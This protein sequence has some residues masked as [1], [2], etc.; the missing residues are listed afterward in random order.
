MV[1]CRKSFWQD[2][3]DYHD[4]GGATVACVEHVEW[5]SDHCTCCL[6]VV[7]MV[8]VDWLVCTRSPRASPQDS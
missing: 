4:Y 8:M 6:A 3:E 7:I 5:L 1:G 2:Y